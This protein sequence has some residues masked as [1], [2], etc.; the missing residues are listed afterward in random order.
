MKRLV[1]LIVAVTALLLLAPF[2]A[3]IAC[4]IRR[5]SPGP[6]FYRGRRAGRGGGAFRIYKFRTMV[7][8][9]ERLGGPTTAGDDPRLTPLGKR[10]RRHKLDEL[11][12]LINVAR[13]EMSLVG[14]RPEVLSKVARYSRKEKRV[15]NVRPGITDWASIWNADEGAALAG[16]G[17]PDAAYERW[18]RPTKLRLQL[19]YCEQSSLWV[20]AK[21]LVYTLLKLCRR[22]W[23]PPELDGF[24]P[25]AAARWARAEPG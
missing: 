24:E 16:L 3:A 2:L 7:V 17:D 23:L 5:E 13:G 19:L 20:D 8:G 9:A 18:I 14:P 1:D 12:Q 6:V 25:L 15:L 10:L 11:P 22:D 4:R 21:I